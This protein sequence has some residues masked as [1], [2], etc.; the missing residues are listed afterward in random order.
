MSKPTC[1]ETIR[2][3]TTAAFFIG[4]VKRLAE[5]PCIKKVSGTLHLVQETW[6][7]RKPKVPS[8]KKVSGTLPLVQET[9]RPRKPKVPG[10]FFMHF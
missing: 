10:T 9:W 1:C 8:I 2:S 7:P 4:L 5:Q 3:C 6:R